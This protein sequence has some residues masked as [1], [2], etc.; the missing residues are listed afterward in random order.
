MIYD[1]TVCWLC[2]IAGN[3]Y[4]KGTWI[5]MYNN[6]LARFESTVFK[7]VLEKM[8]PFAESP[9]NFVEIGSSK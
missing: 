7:S 5:D 9:K 8:A 6:K 2:L 3:G 1:V 4:G